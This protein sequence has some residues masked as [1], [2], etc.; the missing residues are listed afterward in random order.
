MPAPGAG[1][2]HTWF[3]RTDEILW[4]PVRAV[5]TVSQQSITAAEREGAVAGS[6]LRAGKAEPVVTVSRSCPWP[7][8]LGV[9]QEAPAWPGHCAPAFTLSPVEV[10]SGGSPRRTPVGRHRTP[11]LPGS[12]QAS[13]C[14]GG[15]PSHR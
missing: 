5:P 6:V 10:E 13:L 8:L 7:C 1:Q 4:H 15:A 2:P 3:D 12:S 9:P 11:T 14:E